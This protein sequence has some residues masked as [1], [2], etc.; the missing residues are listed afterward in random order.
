M[1]KPEFVK[2]IK[3]KRKV[4]KYKNWDI[5]YEKQILLSANIIFGPQNYYTR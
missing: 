5:I 4:C 2:P 3:D 1:Y